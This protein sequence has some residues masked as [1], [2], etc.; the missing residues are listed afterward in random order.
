MTAD[1]TLFDPRTVTD[2]ASWEDSKN[3]LPSTGIPYVLV[4]GCFSGLNQ[5]T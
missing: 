2:N 3:T 4:N 5:Y 1:L